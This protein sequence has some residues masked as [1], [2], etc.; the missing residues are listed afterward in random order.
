M[1]IER[2]LEPARLGLAGEN[3]QAAQ[4]RQAGVLQNRKLAR[5]RG[6]VLRLDAADGEAALLLAAV[7]ASAFLR[8]FLTVIF[9]TK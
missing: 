1:S 3:S 6:E 8:L 7:S 9:V 4:N 2:V 5:E